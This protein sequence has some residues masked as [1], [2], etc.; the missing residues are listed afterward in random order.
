M[1][2][3]PAFGEGGETIDEAVPIFALPFIDA[4][5]T[6]NDNDDYDEACPNASIGSPDV[7]YVFTPDENLLITISLC[8]SG[9]DTKLYVYEGGHTPGN[10]VACN[11]DACNDAQGNP[12]RSRVDDLPVVAD[13]DYYIVIDGSGG[14]GGPYELQVTI[15]EPCE[16]S[17]PPAS[18][19]ENE[20][21]CADGYEDVFNSGC[22]AT[23]D[24]IFSPIGCQDQVCGTSGTFLKLGVP[25]PDA[26][27]YEVELTTD[28]PLIWAV[29]AE[30][31][32][33]LFVLGGDNGCDGIAMLGMTEASACDVATIALDSVGAGVYWLWVGPIAFDGVPCGALY[34]ASVEC[35]QSSCPGDIDGDGIVAVSDLLAILA[36]WG[37]AD[38][39]ADLND[40]G[41]V[42]VSDLLV[43]LGAWGPC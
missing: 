24:P 2:V 5:E 12:F 6:S 21:V 9:Y 11:D 26:D 20:P 7:V 33:R 41:V 1:V 42:D 39:D 32:V 19:P 40:D 22:D 13:S 28:G 38:P 23:G 36:A 8:D 43:L 16:L 35:T 17:C 31:D 10:P 29:I 30:F 14:Q 25:R 4:G 18:L 27:W 15:A 37:G 3:A 34:V